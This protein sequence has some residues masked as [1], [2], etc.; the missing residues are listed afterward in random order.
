MK[1]VLE[2]IRSFVGRHE[3]PIKPLTI[4]TGEN[5]S[6]KTTFLSTL[7]AVCS[8]DYPQQA[9][10][11]DPPY[12]LGSF[13]TIATYKGGPHGRAKFFSIGYIGEPDSKGNAAEMA[14]TYI[15]EQGQVELSK[16]T[17]RSNA[18][19][20]DLNL[21]A[22]DGKDH[23]VRLV[24]FNRKKR[25]SSAFQ[26]DKD[27]LRTTSQSIQ[28]ILR[29]HFVDSTRSFK[30]YYVWSSAISEMFSSVEPTRA[31]SIAPIRT[32]PSRTYDQ[33]TDD[34]NPEGSH[35]PLILARVLSEG[36]STKQ[37]RPLVAALERFGDESGLFKHIS[38]KKLGVSVSDP[39]QVMVTSAGR[40]ANILDVGYG[41]SQAL[42]VVV[43]S[44]LL[45]ESRLLLLQQPEVHLH[46]KA[47]AALGTF[48]VDLITEA[49]KRFVIETHS[50]YIVD[51]VRQEVAAGRVSSDEVVILFFEKTGTE[52]TIYPI[53]LDKYGNIVGAPPSYRSFFL[54][55]ELN[56][57]NRTGGND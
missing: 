4:L 43:Q 37:K 10:F 54:R 39:F 12:N 22:M 8:P 23:S 28:G 2:N 20:L 46:P 47:Q 53:N 14:A 24:R 27:L 52:T 1:L 36:R 16:F 6:G 51:R 35:I 19:E 9:K 21:G 26:I 44:V 31:L 11:N 48:F 45:A 34:F 13:D 41:V 17:I 55:E 30:S 25:T 56:L 29:N 50:D 33:V 32:K 15:S 18:G 38:V 49:D 5:S 3:V 7:S 40:P 57:L 42:P